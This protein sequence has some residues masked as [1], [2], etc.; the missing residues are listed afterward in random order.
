MIGN[1][2]AK[3]IVYQY[4]DFACSHCAE[5]NAVIDQMIKEYDG[6][7]ALVFRNY[8]LSGYPNNVEA[9]AAVTAAAIQGYWEKYKNLVFSDQAT[10]VYL[11]SSEAVPYFVQLFAEAS[12]G[13][14]DLEKFSK[15][16][17]S[18]AVAKRIA[19]DYAMASATEL[20]G[21]PTFRINGEK[22]PATDLQTTIEKLLKK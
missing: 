1:K 9:A 13:E 2:N 3:V 22:I 19:F 4:A 12:D 14:G 21:T 7:V 16:M 11:K 6:Q 17:A 20:T 18:D 10:W 5:L 8:L 15:D